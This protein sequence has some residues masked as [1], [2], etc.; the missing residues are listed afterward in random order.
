[1]VNSL[2]CLILVAF[3]ISTQSAGAQE[4]D[5][6]SE[7]KLKIDSSTTQKIA[8]ADKVDDLLTNNLLRAYSGS[9]SRISISNS[10]N[11]DGGTVSAPFGLARPNI[12]GASGN[13][14][15]TDLNDQV[16]IKYNLDSINSIVLGFGVR[17]IA[18]FERSGPDQAWYASGGKDIDIF[19]PSLIYQLIY[20]MAAIQAVAQFEFIEFTRQDIISSNVDQ[21]GNNL[22]QQFSFDQENIYEIPDTNWSIGGSFGVGGNVPTD[23]RQD[24]SQYQIWA[25]PYV[26]FAVT[27]KANLRAILTEWYY[28][29]WR[30]DGLIRDTVTMTVGLG[31]SVTRDLYVFPN[32]M[33]LPDNIRGNLTNVGV[34][35]T[36]NLF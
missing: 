10:I 7:S 32:V 22:A 4:I 33:F 13:S 36:L 14:V 20:K 5:A 23:R 15:E 2:K 17:K 18:P 1:M 9:T 16:G 19:D 35:T 34:T 28:E 26:E 25:Y 21:G 12:M 8:D 27:E 30:D 29:I 31:Y 24:W 3:I 6:S 11:Y